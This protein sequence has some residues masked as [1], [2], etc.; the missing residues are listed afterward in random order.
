[1]DIHNQI[2]KLIEKTLDGKIDWKTINPTA[3]RWT[4]LKGN[5]QYVTTFQGVNIPQ[6]NLASNPNIPN[7]IG[8]GTFIFTLQVTNPP[9]ETLIQ[10]QVS[11]HN[12]AEYLIELNKLYNIILEKTKK[13]YSKILDELLDNL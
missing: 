9:G 10:L 5:L 3:F 7:Q 12:N 4:V 13:D 6:Q 1:M 11:Q 8:N 2:N